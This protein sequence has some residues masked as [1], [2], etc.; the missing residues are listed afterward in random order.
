MIS[1]R[2][3]KRIPMAML[4]LAL[5]LSSAFLGYSTP[6][7]AAGESQIR[8]TELMY[9]PLGS[10]DKEFIELY[11]GSD[12]VADMSGWSFS[13][14]VNYTFASGAKLDP[15]KYG[16][17]TRNS[18][19]FRGSYPSA[20]VLGQYVGKLL[21]RGELVK[22]VNKNGGT[23]S[24]V[25]YGSTGAWPSAPRNGGPSLSLIRPNANETLAGCW[26]TSTATGGSPGFA[27]S[28]SGGG[29]CSNKA[30]PTTP[31]V[32]PGGGG[33]SGSG[34]SSGGGGSSPS[35][36]APGIESSET[37]SGD[38]G[39]QE[40]QNITPEKQAELEAQ[41]EQEE[42]EDNQIDIAAQVGGLAASEPAFKKL[43]GSI[44]G[45][46]VIILGISYV[47]FEKLHK[48][49]T[50]HGSVFGK[51]FAKLK[52]HFRKPNRK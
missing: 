4:C 1:I 5:I 34:G 41:S 15:G 37:P 26:G 24:E 27:N 40:L 10:G 28:A 11:N 42:L 12:S 23:V 32:A 22:L 6:T 45:L 16:V 8:I 17:V 20:R 13:N 49:H 31:T 9:D 2:N 46:F 7:I 50:K 36:P 3:C 14:G 47:A 35:S 18:A 21:G 39:D 43:I 30:Y 25:N 52:K 51:N 33:G 48:K 29:S 44:L 19:V 38:T